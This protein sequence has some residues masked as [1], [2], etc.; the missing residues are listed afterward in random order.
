M[1]YAEKIG[2]S[3]EKCWYVEKLLHELCFCVHYGVYNQFHIS[4]IV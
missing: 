3:D 4:Q 1:I 2:T